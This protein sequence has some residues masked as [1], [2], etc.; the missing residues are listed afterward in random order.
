MK[1]TKEQILGKLKTVQVP[2]SNQTVA[3][4]VKE[5]NISKNS[6]NVKAELDKKSMPL[7]NSLEKVIKNIISELAGKDIDIKLEISEGLQFQ[8]VNYQLCWVEHCRHRLV[9]PVGLYFP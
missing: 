3:D 9:L 5:I 6:I 8:Q 4:I 7:K 2:E 1:I